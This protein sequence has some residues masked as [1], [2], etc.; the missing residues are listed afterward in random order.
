MPYVLFFSAFAAFTFRPVSSLRFSKYIFRIFQQFN[1]LFIQAAYTTRALN[2]RPNHSPATEK[3]LPAPR[4]C[5]IPLCLTYIIPSKFLPRLMVLRY[6]GASRSSFSRHV[7]KQKFLFYLPHN[8]NTV[9]LR[10]EQIQI[11]NLT[12]GNK[13]QYS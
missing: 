2:L 6:L 8:G 7:N 11:L 10:Q 1:A 4:R 12:E 9:F 13:R 5:L 3:C